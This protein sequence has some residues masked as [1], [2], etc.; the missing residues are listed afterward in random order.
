MTNSALLGYGHERTVCLYGIRSFGLHRL[1]GVVCLRSL[2]S[3]AGLVL[4]SRFESLTYD[5]REFAR[6]ILTMWAKHFDF[7]GSDNKFF[8]T[9]IE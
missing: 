3:S 9:A 7:Y 4:R 1:P 5:P 8:H 2:C 6:L